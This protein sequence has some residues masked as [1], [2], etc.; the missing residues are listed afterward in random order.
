MTNTDIR[1]RLEGEEAEYD[2]AAK[3]HMAPIRKDHPFIDTVIRDNYIMSVRFNAMAELLERRFGIAGKTVL[4]CGCGGAYYEIA[5]AKRGASV[6]AYDISSGML[7]IARHNA[8]IHDT[9]LRL[10]RSDELNLSQ[11]LEKQGA[12]PIDIFWGASILHH[13]SSPSDF[14][15]VMAQ[16]GHEKSVAVFFE[17]VSNKIVDRVRNS[18]L[19]VLHKMQTEHEHVWTQ[20][21]YRAYLQGVFR[22]VELLYPL[23]AVGGLQKVMKTFLPNKLVD[24]G[25]RF[26]L[27]SDRM[28]GTVLP[29]LTWHTTLLAYN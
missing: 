2:H 8:R 3:T 11:D 28:L 17:P 25:S 4:G 9:Q 5:L 15:Q 22:N 19:N 20:E 10:F 27:A 12:P 1:K 7:D 18:S 29:R 23:N 6:W 24:S 16:R 13:L 26:A 14:L 21:A